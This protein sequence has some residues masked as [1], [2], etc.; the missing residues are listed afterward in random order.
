VSRALVII[1]SVDNSRWFVPLLGPMERIRTV[2]NFGNDDQRAEAISLLKDSAD[3]TLAA[4]TNAGLVL[5]SRDIEYHAHALWVLAFHKEELSRFRL[6]R[7]PAST[8]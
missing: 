7:Q 4:C 2:I 6:Q 3:V 8:R 5:E 1:T